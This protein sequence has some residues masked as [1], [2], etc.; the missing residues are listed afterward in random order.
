MKKLALSIFATLACIFAAKADVVEV[1]SL[2]SGSQDVTWDN[3]LNI[4]ASEFASGVE[5]GHY[6]L[7]NLENA[8]DVLEIKANGVWLPGSIFTNIEGKSEYK[9]YITS[10][11]LSA[12]KEYG[13]EIIGKSFTVTSVKIM[14]DGTTVP[15]G[16]IWAGY[17]WADSW[18]T[19]ELF[20]T[21]FNVYQ[22]EADA[23]NHF[24][25]HTKLII[26]HEAGY[27]YY[28]LNV[29]TQFDNP[30]A[31]WA[32]SEKNLTKG[33]TQVTVDISG[34]DANQALADVNTLLLQFNKEGGNGFNVTSIVLSDEKGVT[35]AAEVSMSDID[36]MMPTTVYNLQGIAVKHNVLPAEAL[37]SLPKGLYII[38]G[39]KILNR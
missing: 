9:A 11:M 36:E 23:E 13:L 17:F 5:V 3:S 21:A 1:K 24:L 28:L 20:K 6:I 39:K 12:L 2:Y 7:I 29:M 15:D 33:T 26:N 34:I 10:P 32:N 37:E 35:G 19:M 4:E 22:K 25:G 16:A 31:V 38:N 27:D 8:T 18:T 30:D 14:N